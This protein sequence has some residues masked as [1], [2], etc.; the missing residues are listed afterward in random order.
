MA[1]KMKGPAFFKSAL[2]HSKDVKHNKQFGPGHDWTA[3]STGSEPKT[4]HEAPGPESS[5]TKFLEASDQES[6]LEGGDWDSFKYPLKKKKLKQ[7]VP[8]ETLKA[9]VRSI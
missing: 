5:P 8:D 7:N 1:Y 9:Q 6:F 3:V 2:K 4:I